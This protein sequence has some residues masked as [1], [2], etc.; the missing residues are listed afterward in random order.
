MLKKLNHIFDV[1]G[2]KES[3]DTLLKGTQ[4]K[5]WSGSLSNELGRLAQGIRDVKGNDVVDVISKSEVPIDH[6]VTDVNMVCDYRHHKDEKYRVCLTVGGDRLVYNDNA[7]S[8]GGITVGNKTVITKIYMTHNPKIISTIPLFR[9]VPNTL[10][11]CVHPYTS[12]Y[13]TSRNNSRRLRT[14]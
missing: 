14:I 4:A 13:M 6:I 1:N 11:V 2:H 8:P 12:T 9:S 5:T 3:I 7:A 10:R